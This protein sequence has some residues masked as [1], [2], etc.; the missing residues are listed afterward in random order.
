VDSMVPNDILQLLADKFG[1]DV[2][3]EDE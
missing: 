3:A 2:S 1:A